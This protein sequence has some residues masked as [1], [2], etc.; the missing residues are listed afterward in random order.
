MQER[1]EARLGDHRVDLQAEASE[2]VLLT[3]LMNND[4][5]R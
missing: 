5:S 4:S 2:S 3:L 1:V